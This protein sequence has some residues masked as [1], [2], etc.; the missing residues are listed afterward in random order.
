MGTPWGGSAWRCRVERKEV[1]IHLREEVEALPK[2]TIAPG[3]RSPKMPGIFKTS[4]VLCLS[5][6][7]LVGGVS[8]IP[9]GAQDK[10]WW[11]AKVQVQRDGKMTEVDYV[12]LQ[13]KASKKWHL[14]VLMPHLK[15]V[16]LV[17]ITYGAV[18]EA[19]RRGVKLTV[20]EAGGYENLSRQI[21]QYDDAMAMGA[22]AIIVAV[23]SEK[24]LTKKVE[25]GKQKG[26]VQVAFLNPVFE[27]PF[28]TVTSPNIELMSKEI[29]LTLANKFKDKSKVRAVLFPGPPGSGWAELFDQAFRKF[30]EEAAPG[31]LEVLASKYGETG[32]SVQL[33]MVEDVLQTY[34]DVDLLYGCAPMAEVAPAILEER[35]LAGKTLVF[36]EYQNHLVHKLIK[37]KKVY[38]MG[39]E[40][41]IVQGGIAVDSAIRALEKKPDGLPAQK[42]TKTRVVTVDNVDQFDPSVWYAPEGYQPIMKVE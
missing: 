17:S 21:S 33:K 32:K 4:I 31:K 41:H 42:I 19:R 6:F 8:V 27:A 24:A 38:G 35:G 34:R 28:D 23:I 11:P 3:E 26:I 39:T 10:P 25:E 36:C 1:R 12:P 9:A 5:G 18:M 29:V 37:D 13:E 22:D 2:R 30:F 7:I 16:G 15:D 20:L 40:E 14:V